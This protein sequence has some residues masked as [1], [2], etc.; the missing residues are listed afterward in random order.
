MSEIYVTVLIDD[1]EHEI[2]PNMTGDNSKIHAQQ[3]AD[4]WTGLGHTAKVGRIQLLK[5]AIPEG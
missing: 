2:I 3:K 5:E 1:G 4:Y